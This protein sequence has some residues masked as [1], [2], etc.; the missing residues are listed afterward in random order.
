[1]TPMTP[2]S[3]AARAAGILMSL[4][5]LPGAHGIGD[6]G[7]EA[8]RFVDFLASSGQSWWQTLPVGPVGRGNSPYDSSS[9]FA[10][11]PMYIS[12]ETLVAKRLLSKSQIEPVP[13]LRVRRV[14]YSEVTRYKEARLRRAFRTFEKKNP[15]DRGQ[16]DDFRA[17]N[18]VWL[19]DFGLFAALKRAFGGA[20]WNSWDRDIRI[21]KKASLRRVRAKLKREIR[22]QEF[23]QYL[24]ESQWQQ[25]RARCGRR[26]IGLIGDVPYFVAAESADVWANQ[27]VFHL[28]ERGRPTIVAGTP[29]D[30]FS[31]TGQMWGNPIYRWGTLREREYDW[32]VERFRGTFR[33][34]D[35]VRLDHFIGFH[36]C[37]AVSGKARTAKHGRWVPGSG[38]PLFDRVFRILGHVQLIAEDLGVVTPEVRALRDD[39]GL[40]SIRV[41]QFAFGKDPDAE[42]HKPHNHPKNCVVYTGTHDNDTTIGWF[43]D[44]KTNSTTRSK[45]D[46]EREL[47]FALRYLKSDGHEVNWDMIRLAFMSVANLAIIPMQDFLGLGSWARMNVPGT[48]HGNW[49]WRISGRNLTPSLTRRIIAITE[50]Y[51]RLSGS[52]TVRKGS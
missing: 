8:H 9:A 3:L 2:K 40:P 32:W 39:V 23:L 4:S 10:G 19:A 17:K 47:A 18:V 24:F 35:A 36:R 43:T 48:E 26:G 49:E 41:L 30:Y 50:T 14:N 45:A 21:R 22:Y 42:N 25:L 46:I 15:S 7:P 38:K 28:D 31:S 29:P 44:R 6:L 16:F 1:M 11:N 33:R 13:T 20:P 27:E 5:S 52:P 51:G 37:W 12:L 34:F